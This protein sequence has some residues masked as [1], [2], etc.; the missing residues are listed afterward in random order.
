MRIRHSYILLIADLL[1]RQED[2]VTA[3]NVVKDFVDFI[4]DSKKQSK[5]D[6]E[7]AQHL[8]SEIKEKEML[9]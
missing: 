5:E 1:K 6:L 7:N 4:E 8:Y 3:K 9:T 2:I